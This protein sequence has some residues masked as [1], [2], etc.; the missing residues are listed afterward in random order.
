MYYL[1]QYK[2]KKFKF[3][4]TKFEIWVSTLTS[5]QFYVLHETVKLKQ[6]GYPRVGKIFNSL[7]LLLVMYKISSNELMLKQVICFYTL[8]NYWL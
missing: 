1:L 5:I 4:M 3:L 7:N 2:N 8:H 6:N